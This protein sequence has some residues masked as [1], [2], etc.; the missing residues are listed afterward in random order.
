MGIRPLGTSLRISSPNQTGKAPVLAG[1]SPNAGKTSVRRGKIGCG[2]SL[3]RTSLWFKFPGSREFCREFLSKSWL[4]TC[5]AT[6][7]AANS[8]GCGTNSL[9]GRAGNYCP[10]AA[11]SIAPSKVQFAAVL[12]LLFNVTGQETISV[13]GIPKPQ[14]CCALHNAMPMILEDCCRM[15]CAICNDTLGVRVFVP[16]TACSMGMDNSAALPRLR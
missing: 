1:Y 10:R 12:A 11:S 8:A 13:Q 9:L 16:I 6:D 14:L 3:W 4:A 5:R 7:W 2:R 15:Q